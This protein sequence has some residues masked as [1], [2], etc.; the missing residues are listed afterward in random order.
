VVNL[1]GIIS[2]IPANG[3]TRTQG[4]MVIHSGVLAVNVWGNIIPARYA[5]PLVV[6]AGDTVVVDLMAGPTGQAE[7]VVSGKLT[8]APRPGTG[9]VATVPPSSPTITVTG[10]DGIGY[11]AYFVGSY[12]PTVN[13]NVILAWNAA[14]PT[15]TGK[16]GATP[17]PA[18]LPPPVTPPPPPPATGLNTYPATD[19]STYW[20]GGGWDSVN[21]GGGNVYQGTVYG[22]S[23]VVY[24]A[25]FYAGSPNELAGRTFNRVQVTIGSRRRVGNYNTPTTV[26]V[27]IHSSA[28]RPGGN[29]SSVAG[30]YDFTIQP[31]SGQVTLDLPTSTG[32]LIANN[33]GIEISG[34]PYAGFNGRLTEPSSGLLQM[35]WTR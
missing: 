13:D 14:T 29:V 7:A 22:T 11:T 25:W 27:Y 28:N 8:T 30:P 34:D 1:A 15:V 33:G 35:T 9:T 2:K 10:T 32:P 20:A 4:T 31:G 19:S 21:G 12:T 16:V 17:A 18:P 26:H 24:G 5:D 23:N 3:L 6:N